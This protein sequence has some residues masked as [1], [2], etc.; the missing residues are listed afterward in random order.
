[1]FG[2]NQDPEECGVCLMPFEVGETLKV[3]NCPKSET[4]DA[5]NVHNFHVDCILKWFEK[6]TDCPFCRTNYK[7]KIIEFTEKER[8]QTQVERFEEQ[9]A[10]AAIYLE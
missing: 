8:I 4:Q 9:K 1:M 6:K 2:G 5:D 10:E 7:D 3:L